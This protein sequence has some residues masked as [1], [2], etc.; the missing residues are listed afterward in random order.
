M[1]P[2]VK[3]LVAMD[4]GVDASMLQASLPSEGNIQ[5][6]GVVEGLD[7][8]WDVLQETPTDLLV[9]ACN[10]F[11]DKAIYLID[12]AVKQKPERPVVVLYTGSPNGFVRRVFEVGADDII[13]LPADPENMQFAIEKVLARRSGGQ[14]GSGIATAPLICV[15]GP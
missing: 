15:L 14:T 9:I 5:I 13:S 10:G 11:S 3:A 4:E 12:G 6:V 1:T 7:A 2:R 8:S